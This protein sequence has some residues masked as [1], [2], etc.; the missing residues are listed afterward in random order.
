MIIIIGIVVLAK[1]ATDCKDHYAGVIVVVFF[2]TV[3]VF[4][5]DV[6]TD[7]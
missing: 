4:A 7:G 3:F 5:K 1:M 6:T 2:V